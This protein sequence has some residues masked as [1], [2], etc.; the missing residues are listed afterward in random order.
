MQ[1]SWLVCLATVHVRWTESIAQKVKRKQKKK[2]EHSKKQIW[3]SV[4]EPQ[5][6]RVQGAEVVSTLQIVLLNGDKV[7]SSFPGQNAGP[8]TSNDAR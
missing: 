2:Q 3:K 7:I 5:L 1:C 6:Q 8:Q 4:F